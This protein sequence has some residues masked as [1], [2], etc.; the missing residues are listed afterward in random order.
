MS[1]QKLF[2][3]DSNVNVTNVLDNFQQDKCLQDMSKVCMTESSTRVISVT[4]F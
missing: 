3:K 1:I 4:W 2:T